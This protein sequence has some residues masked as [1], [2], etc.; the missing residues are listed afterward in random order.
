MSDYDR[1]CF[2]GNVGMR[3]AL[4]LVREWS[5]EGQFVTTAKGKL[6]LELQRSVGDILFNCRLDPERIWTVEV[7]TEQKPKP[8][9]FLEYWSN[10]RR[11]TPGWLFTLKA[12][13]LMYQ[14]YETGHLFIIRLPKLKEWA[15][16][17]REHGREGQIYRKGHHLRLQREYVQPNDTWGR[18]VPI[19]TIRREVGLVEYLWVEGRRW[20]F[21]GR[22][23]PQSKS[24]AE[25]DRLLA[26]SEQ[27]MN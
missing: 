22:S 26:E 18:C 19:E 4:L 7:K 2:I 10:A 8:N 20:E 1:A 25:A 12:E 15:F 17:D 23:T 16:I 5:H 27:V 24:H 3:R 14:F 6:S 21:V 13:L 9:F 11:F